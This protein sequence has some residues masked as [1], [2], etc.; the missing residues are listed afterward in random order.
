MTTVRIA[1]GDLAGL[2]ALSV[3]ALALPFFEVRAQPRAVAGF[4]DWRLCGRIARLIASGRFCGAKDEALLMPGLGRCGAQRV[5][6]LGLGKPAAEVGFQHTVKVLADASAR[7][8]AF[9]FPTNAEQ[10]SD[11]AAHISLVTQFLKAMGKQKS[12]FEALTILDPSGALV[13]ASKTLKQ[14]AL[15]AGLKW[16]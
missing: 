6:L 15:N 16:I 7:K 2:D 12:A 14:S 5:F 9:G 13:S 11:S 1:A 10:E 4:V 8:L 3:D